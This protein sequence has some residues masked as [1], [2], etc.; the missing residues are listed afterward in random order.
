MED[1]RETA[2]FSLP[3]PP[4]L[5][6]PVQNNPEICSLVC[7]QERTSRSVPSFATEVQEIYQDA[8]IFVTNAR[9]RRRRQVFL[10]IQER[11]LSEN[12]KRNQ[13]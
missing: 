4:P 8:K 3:S 13:S 10:G 1:R 2:I 6:Y 7:Q 9:I 11:Q 5:Q 12:S